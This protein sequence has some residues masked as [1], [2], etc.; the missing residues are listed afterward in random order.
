MK[1]FRHEE[2]SG[3]IYKLNEH[4]IKTTNINILLNRVRSS[5]RRDVKKLF[6]TTIIIILSLLSYIVFI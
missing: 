6:L 1:N 5:K 4:E 3:K 2:K